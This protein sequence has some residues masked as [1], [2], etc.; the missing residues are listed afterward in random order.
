MPHIVYIPEGF[1]P[2][3][4]LFPELLDYLSED[5]LV[6]KMILLSRRGV[7]AVA[8]LDS[9]CEPI[10]RILRRARRRGI[11]DRTKQM[12][13]HMVRQIMESDEVGLEWVGSARLN[14]WI[15]SAG[16]K[17]RHPS[18]QP[19]WVHRSRD[20]HDQERFCISRRKR[21]AD[22]DT[23]PDDRSQW[24]LYR[25]CLMRHELVYI[26]NVRNLGEVEWQDDDPVTWNSLGRRVRIE[27]FKILWRKDNDS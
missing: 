24:V 13:G 7:P 11:E 6:A 20:G 17:Y 9:D 27:G 23:P 26:L 2:E 19:L 15:F 10:W 22:L 25:R 5:E 4:E 8:A 18:W 21:L 3:Y 14:S 1:A 16:A 12:I